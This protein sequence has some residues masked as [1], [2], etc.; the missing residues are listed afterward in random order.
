MG[1]SGRFQNSGLRCP[2]CNLFGNRLKAARHSLTDW[3]QQVSK[4]NV[5]PRLVN[6]LSI[7]SSER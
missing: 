5:L 1:G 4:Q 6:A 7:M 3:Q 2:L